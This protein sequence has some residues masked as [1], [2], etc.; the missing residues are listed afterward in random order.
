MIK[1]K[2]WI[3]FALAAGLLLQSCA[4]KPTETPILKIA[5]LP[6]IDAVPIYAAQQEGLFE[7]HG[8]QVEIIPVGAAPER[9]Q[10]IS[11]NQADGEINETASVMLFNRESTQL[12]IVRYALRPT[13][14][15]PHFYILTSAKSGITKVDQLKGVEIGVSQ[16]T[17]IEYVTDRLLESQ[18]FTADEIKV[19]AVPKISD[20]MNLLASG[21]LSAGTMPDPLASLAM[22][23]G[24]VNVIDDSKYPQYGY[25]V[26]SFRKAVIDANPEAIKAFLAALEEATQQV[27]ADPAKFANIMSEQKLVPAPLLTSYRLPTYPTAGVPTLDEWND[28]MQWMLDKQLLPAKVDYSTSVTDQFL[29]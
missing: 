17:V 6:V 15:S 23:Q 20:R 7:K 21:E 16:G 3:V 8:V 4:P 12:Q 29:P 10:L 22:Q 14:D 9:E 11:A 5:L 26:I 2:A 25:S 18:G 24:S 19:L 1:L 28:T 27:N 13:A